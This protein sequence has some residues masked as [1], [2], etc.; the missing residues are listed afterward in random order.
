MLCLLDK[1]PHHRDG[2]FGG[3]GSLKKEKWTECSSHAGVVP[4]FAEDVGWV[5]STR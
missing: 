4:M 1:V 5:E 3:H 2:T